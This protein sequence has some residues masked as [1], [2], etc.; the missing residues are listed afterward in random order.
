MVDDG[1]EEEEMTEEDD[2]EKINEEEDET[3]E[4]KMAEEVKEKI[5]EENKKQE[6]Q[7]DTDS[8]FSL[9]FGLHQYLIYHCQPHHTFGQR[10]ETLLIETCRKFK[11]NFG[12]I[13]WEEVS[14]KLNTDVKNMPKS[15]KISK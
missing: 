14:K 6:D 3:Q 13:K 15:C 7:N 9:S 2:K 1:E 5:N 10:K 8:V 4:E 12:Y 11:K